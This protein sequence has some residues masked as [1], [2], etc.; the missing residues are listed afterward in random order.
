MTHDP[1][2]ERPVHTGV[3]RWVLGGLI[4]TIVERMGVVVL[5]DDALPDNVFSIQPGAV[6]VIY[7]GASGHTY[8][9]REMG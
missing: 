3:P 2:T 1:R 5:R 4:D 6:N 8:T 7:H 9:G